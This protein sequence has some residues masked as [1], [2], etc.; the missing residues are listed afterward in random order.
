[1]DFLPIFLNLKNYRCLV[2]GGGEV[3]TRKAQLLLEAGAQVKIVA[4]DL[5]PELEKLH[6][7]KALQYRLGNFEASDLSDCF[8]VI[9]ATDDAQVNAEVAGLAKQQ[10]ALLNVVDQPELGNYILPS[11]ISRDPLQIAISSGGASPALSRMLRIKLETLIPSGYGQLAQLLR[12]FRPQVKAFFSTGEQRRHFWEKILGSPIAELVLSGQTQAA[13]QAL[14]QQLH[15]AEDKLETKSGEVYLVGGGPGD[16]DLLTFRALRLMQ[17]ADVVVHDRLVSKA[18][19]NLTRT[20]A[21]RVYV[22][23]ERSNHAVPQENINKLL[24][25]LAKEGNRVLRL[26]GGDPFIFGRGG[27]EIETLAAEGVPF[28]VVPGITAASGTAAYA[29]IPLTH[30][31][32]AQ[33]CVF[34]TGHLKD[35]TMNLNWDLLTQ[36]QQTVVV[37]MGLLAL[38]I[39][40]Q[41]LMK[42]GLPAK[43][44]IALV[45]Q[46]T[47][48]N[49][50]VFT[51]TLGTLPDIIRDAEV[52]PPSLLVIGDVVT[53]QDKL[54]WFKP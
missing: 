23:K 40:C 34:V 8:L 7:E 24:A 33:S 25:R 49:Q 17:Q 6:Q 16:P 32:Y 39:L 5:S 22:G 51:G 11:I 4:P 28:Q 3:A 31:D 37:Y 45:Q 42:H 35:G 41:E 27:E 20:D 53:L 50:R 19:L 12:K 47:T 13:E 14:E 30:R 1:M 38:P 52:K 29:G 43:K 10:G 36:P 46:A 18:V 54:S 9:A 26:K 21:K 48:K 44:P 2:V 15:N